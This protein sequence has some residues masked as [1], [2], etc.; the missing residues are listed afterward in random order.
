MEPQPSGTPKGKRHP[1]KTNKHHV[2]FDD[3]SDDHMTAQR[4]C[5]D[6]GPDS[7]KQKME[8]FD[9]GSLETEENQNN[10]CTNNENQEAANNS[11]NIDNPMSCG[12]DEDKPNYVGCYERSALQYDNQLFINK[13]R[14]HLTPPITTDIL[15]QEF[16][17]DQKEKYKTYD[18][19]NMFRESYIKSLA[20]KKAPRKPQAPTYDAE[21]THKKLEIGEPVN[22]TSER[23]EHRNEES[24]TEESFKYPDF[25]P[26]YPFSYYS[27]QRYLDVWEIEREIFDRQV[28][29]IRRKPG[30][31]ISPLRLQKAALLSMS[32]PSTLRTTIRPP[33]PISTFRSHR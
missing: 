19:S 28:D 9:E 12:K 16:Y 33:S 17:L 18:Y 7:F 13:Y 25:P 6:R 2:T 3:Q 10:G 15:E 21:I 14:I 27:F 32:R 24:G 11:G 23:S 29:F 8:S 30:R 31:Y 22:E 1:K 5:T 20:P 26:W 4:K